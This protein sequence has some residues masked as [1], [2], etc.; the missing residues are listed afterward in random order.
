MCQ[1]ERFHPVEICQ[2]E[3]FQRVEIN[4]TAD[5]STNTEMSIDCQEQD[6]MY[7]TISIA[8]LFAYE[9]FSSNQVGVLCP[10]LFLTATDTRFSLCYGSSNLNLAKL[11]KLE[12]RIS[13]KRWLTWATFTWNSSGTFKVG[14]HFYPEFSHLIFAKSTRKDLPWGRR[15]YYESTLFLG[16]T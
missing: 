12:G 5:I 6:R 8:I 4:Q 13:F 1:N 10:R 9:P 15:K 7:I 11:W 16:R 3:R 14:S 2:K